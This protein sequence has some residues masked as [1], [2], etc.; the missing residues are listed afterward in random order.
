MPLTDAQVRLVVGVWNQRSNL[1]YDIDWVARRLAVMTNAA[2]LGG[3]ILEVLRD[4]INEGYLYVDQ[5]R[6]LNAFSGFRAMVGLT[7][8]GRA[9]W[10]EVYPTL[11]ANESQSE[12]A[13]GRQW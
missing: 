2:A 10:A 7:P 5:I 4:A 13:T 12:P 9:V 1:V 3:P 11:A 6:A 8:S